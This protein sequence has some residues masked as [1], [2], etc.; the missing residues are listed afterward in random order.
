MDNLP[1]PPPTKEKK[2][3]KPLLKN[4]MSL[5]DAGDHASPKIIIFFIAVCFFSLPSQRKLG[6]TSHKPLWERYK[7]ITPAS[8]GIGKRVGQTGFYSFVWHLV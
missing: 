5:H 2:E 8:P 3:N 1:S 7:S 4:S 6:F